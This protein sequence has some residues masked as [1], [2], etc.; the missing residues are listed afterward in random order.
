M[1]E[2]WEA[3]DVLAREPTGGATLP[4]AAKPRRK[5]VS[6]SPRATR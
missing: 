4:K 6:A 3:L 2:K 1:L 5:A